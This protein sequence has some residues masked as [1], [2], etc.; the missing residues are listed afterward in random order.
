MWLT[1]LRREGRFCWT[2]ID[3]DRLLPHNLAR[4][5]GR[6]DGVFEFKANIL[7]RHLDE[8]LT[9]KVPT[10]TIAANLFPSKEGGDEVQEA[11][12]T[13]DLIIDATASILAARHLSDHA[14]R[15]RRASV[16]FN[17][18]GTAAVLLAEP[19]DREV[20][21]RDIE[22]QYYALLLRTERL[23]DHLGKEPE[24]LAYTGACRAI[25]SRISQSR[26]AVLSGLAAGGLAEVV[27]GDTGV[28]TIW[29]LSP[30]G[31]VTV[32]TA[33]PE[34][35][36]SFVAHGWKIIIHAALMRDINEMRQLRAPSETGGIL[37]GVVDIPEKRIDLI[38][39][40]AAPPDSNEQRGSF[41]RGVSGV[42]ELMESVRSRTAGQVRYVGE[43]HSHP[44]RSSA[45]PSAVD[46]E[47][48]DWLAALME[49]ESMPA[50]M[51]IAAEHE[52]AVIFADQQAE[53]QAKEAV[54]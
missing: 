1:G 38:Y 17:P 25:T 44:P 13:A 27:D 35:T 37:F 54:A 2:I 6:R 39:A 21:L 14:A 36:K 23:D 32:D 40:S 18:A 11:L 22:A 43:W 28:L 46:G 33:K 41:V 48:I 29:S 51:V 30:D 7:A 5:I 9:S 31:G 24:T 19:A 16:F 47:Q 42:D 20:T 4:H 49:M 52:T 3:D 15:A 26:A 53:P 50:L 12:G 8:T 10:R 34:Q 45:R